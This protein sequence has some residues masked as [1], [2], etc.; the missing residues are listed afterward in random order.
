M[1]KLESSIG[2]DKSS[3]KEINIVEEFVRVENKEDI[4]VIHKIQ[5]ALDEQIT[6][7]LQGDKPNNNRYGLTNQQIAN[8]VGEIYCVLNDD[9][10]GCG[11][12][13]Y[14]EELQK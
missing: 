13:T 9:V 5:K 7:Y 14:S 12:L 11:L 1:L 4:K 8:I 2:V 10:E 6:N 3:G